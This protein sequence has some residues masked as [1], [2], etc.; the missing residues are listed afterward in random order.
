MV[1]RGIAGIVELEVGSCIPRRGWTN[2]R[3]WTVSKYFSHLKLMMVGWWNIGL[4]LLII[5]VIACIVI[6]IVGIIIIHIGVLLAT[7]SPGDI[8][9]SS[10]RIR[11][12]F[13]RQCG[14]LWMLHPTCTPCPS[15]YCSSSSCT[16]P[17]HS[18]SSNSIPHP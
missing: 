10:Y 11:R 12:R 3:S 9:H 1:M 2:N 7:N 8:G 14:S 15:S 17:H 13:G 18:S 16:C 4:L 6:V 5:I